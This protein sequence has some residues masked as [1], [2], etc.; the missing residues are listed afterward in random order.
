MGTSCRLWLIVLPVAVVSLLLAWLDSKK[1]Y[2]FI[3]SYRYINIMDTVLTPTALD[4]SVYDQCTDNPEFSLLV[5]NIKL[6]ELDEIIDRDLP[7][8]FLA[9]DNRAFRRVEFGAT[10]GGDIIR[11]HLFRGLYFHD[12]I[13]NAT[14]ITSV[15]GVT[16]QI[17]V[18]GTNNETIYVGGAYIYKK[19]MLA[20]N[21]VLHFIDRIIGVDY[22]TVPP[23]VS[24]APTITAYPTSLMPPTFAPVSRPSGPTIITFPPQVAID[25]DQGRE[26]GSPPSGDGNDDDS[27]GATAGGK[28]TS[29][30]LLILALFGG[31]LWQ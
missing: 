10:D 29:L 2:F 14:T 15:N 19:D 31:R 1:G 3:S 26:P 17:E 27:S 30:S 5:E 13:A 25:K 22:D 20:W 18:F 23:T 8:T 16:H 6:V 7:L 21:G 9:P 4:R 28:A 24:P 12:E 11:A